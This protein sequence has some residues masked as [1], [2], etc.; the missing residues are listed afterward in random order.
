MSMIRLLSPFRRRRPDFELV[1]IFLNLFLDF[2]EIR[3]RIVGRNL[4]S[5]KLKPFSV[6][7]LVGRLSVSWIV[8]GGLLV[9]RESETSLDAGYFLG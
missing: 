5:S 9:V 8:S 7:E 1:F 3:F 6:T 4:S 2:L